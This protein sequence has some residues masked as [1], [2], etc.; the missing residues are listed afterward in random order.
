MK[1]IEYLTEYKLSLADLEDL[2][3]DL[4]AA[5]A[6]TC[7]AV[8]EINTLMR[9][10]IF[11]S[12][13]VIDNEVI[14]A[15]SMIQ[16]GVL[17][18]TW[19]SKLF[20]FSEFIHL[21]GKHN[22]TKNV[23]LIELAKQAQKSFEQLK[24]EKG[25]DLVRNIRHEASNHYCLNPARKNLKHLSPTSKLSFYL[26]EKNGNSFFPMGEEVMFIGRI[27]RHAT[28]E[29]T[30]EEKSQL[31]N[32]WMNWNLM[33]S[34]WLGEVHHLFVKRLVLERFSERKA[35]R[36]DYWIPPTMV[37][38]VGEIITPI[39]IRTNNHNKSNKVE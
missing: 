4:S 2:H 25:F 10:Y 9:L 31:Y 30:K 24:Q 17:L 38:E 37:G 35:E 16:R 32:T 7:Y 19:S 39:F 6:V 20:E 11:S 34:N 5:L 22:K 27:N 21:N 23:D 3:E 15:A 18:R 8:S 33:A 12:H 26:H 28:S 14:D 1:A 36:K 13:Q 29:T